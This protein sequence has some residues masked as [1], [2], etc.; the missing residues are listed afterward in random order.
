[1]LRKTRRGGGALGAPRRLTCSLSHQIW[2]MMSRRSGTSLYWMTSSSSESMWQET[3]AWWKQITFRLNTGRTV[4]Q[5][6]F[7]A[8]ISA[9]SR[10]SAE[11]AQASARQP[12]SPQEPTLE[13]EGA[14]DT[15]TCGT[16]GTH[17]IRPTVALSRHGSQLGVQQVP[18]FVDALREKQET[19]GLSCGLRGWG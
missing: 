5:P 2:R 10:V 14:S 17:P 9:E 16:F 19:P 7:T 6:G 18:G 3:M 11:N 1:M 8:T 12:V 15:T 4:R 13:K